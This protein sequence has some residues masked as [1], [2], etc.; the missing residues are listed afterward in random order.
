MS[1]ICV[2][3]PSAVASEAISESGRKRDAAAST[4]SSSA[5]TSRRAIGSAPGSVTTI[6]MSVLHRCQRTL[7]E[8][9]VSTR[10]EPWDTE[11]C[12]EKFGAITVVGVR[13]R[14][15]VVGGGA[16]RV[17]VTG[18]GAAAGSADGRYCGVYCGV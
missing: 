9:R 5:S 4:A 13:L 15:L 17:P 7:R 12:G 18:G 8:V 14:R 16:G 10:H 2:G 6:C 1:L 11:T 3:R